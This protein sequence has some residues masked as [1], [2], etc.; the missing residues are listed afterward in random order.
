MNMKSIKLFFTLLASVILLTNLTAC[1]KDTDCGLDVTVV[2][3]DNNT[4]VKDVH[5]TVG[6]QGATIGAD[7]YTD[8]NGKYS[9]TFHA[10]A[11]FDVYA[12]YLV[13][14]TVYDTTYDA[15]NMMTVTPTEVYKGK[16]CNQ[17]S[18][19]LKDGETVDVQLKLDFNHMQ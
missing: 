1:D 7:G 15:Y 17:T 2:R 12:E 19:R 18:V 9:A 3:S 8:A 13:Y 6:K 16:Y 14:G 5:V 4:A 10:P 11:I